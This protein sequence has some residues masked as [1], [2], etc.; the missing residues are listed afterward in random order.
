MDIQFLVT[1]DIDFVGSS[2]DNFMQQVITKYPCNVE[3]LLPLWQ[4]PRKDLL[5]EMLS[6]NFDIK[7]C[8]VKSPHFDASWIGKKLDEETIIDMDRMTSEG[9][10]LTGENGE[11]HTMVVNGPMYKY[12]LH[13]T[14]VTA[15]ELVDQ[16]GQESKERWWVIAETATLKPLRNR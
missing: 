2:T 15:E 8:C 6:H 10:D 16:R 4:Q 5:R 7:L 12:P 11:Y 14:D 9:L 13:F 3:V 1:G